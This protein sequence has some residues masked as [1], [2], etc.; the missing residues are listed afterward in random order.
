MHSGQREVGRISLCSGANT[1]EPR[2]RL[3]AARRARAGERENAR[4]PS[5]ELRVR[6]IDRTPPSPLTFGRVTAPA[7]L[8]LKCTT[9]TGSVCICKLTTTKQK[10]PAGADDAAFNDPSQLDCVRMYFL[11]Y[12]DTWLNGNYADLHTIRS[13]YFPGTVAAP[14]SASVL[15][16]HLQ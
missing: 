12:T 15:F 5:S 4:D 1:A 7:V 8:F 3:T 11:T 13:A 16:V 9:M 6:S 14:T 2:S 10:P